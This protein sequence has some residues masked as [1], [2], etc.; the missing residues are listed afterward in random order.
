MYSALVFLY[1]VPPVTVAI[2][3]KNAKFI[4]FSIFKKVIPVMISTLIL[5]LYKAIEGFFIINLINVYLLNGTELYGLY[6]GA[7]ESLISLPVSLCYGLSVTSIPIISTLKSK[8][9]D[10]KRKSK[11]AITLTLTV[12][13]VLGVGFFIFSPLAVRVLYSKLSATNQA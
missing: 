8:G 7:V 13:L 11:E 6:S 9:E 1:T 3:F 2:S 5:P 12:S 10:Y 4:G